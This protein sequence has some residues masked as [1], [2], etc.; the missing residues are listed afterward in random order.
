IINTIQA[1]QKALDDALVAP[2][3]HLEFG[4]CNMRLKTDIKPKEA[5]FQVVLDA[6]ALTLFYQAFL[7]T[8]E[9]PA[10]YIHEKTQVYDVILPQHLTNQAMLE[11]IAYQTYYAYKTDPASKGSKLKSSAKVAKTDKKKHLVTMPKTKGLSVLS[12]VALT[13]AEQIKLATKRSKTQFYSS[14]A[15]GSGDGVDTQSKVPDEQQQKVS[16]TNERTG[17]RPEVSDVP[18]YDSKSDEE[19]WKFSQD[20]E[21]AD[22]E[23]DVNDDSEETE[24]DNDRDNLTHPNLST[25]KADDQEKEE[26]KVDDEEVSSDQRVSTPPEYELTEEEE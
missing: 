6:L 10:I 17:V 11:S 13:K 18:K 2:T 1:Q 16:G 15:S 8:A 20:E 9:V 24:S 7:I 26:E 5:T 3:N 25:Y 21:D 14:H 22:E 12:E 23:K 4:K 19:S